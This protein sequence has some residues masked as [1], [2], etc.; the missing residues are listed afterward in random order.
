M[1]NLNH[2]GDIGKKQSRVKKKM[3]LSTLIR[4]FHKNSKALWKIQFSVLPFISGIFAAVPKFGF[5]FILFSP[6]HLLSG[7]RSSSYCCQQLHLTPPCFT[8]RLAAVLVST[9]L[10]TWTLVMVRSFTSY[11]NVK[12]IVINTTE[13]TILSISFSGFSIFM[14]WNYLSLNLKYSWD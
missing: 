14:L 10:K 13:L 2:R 1:L 9:L 5:L 7:G 12:R 6:L 4:L 11:Q 3:M 8:P